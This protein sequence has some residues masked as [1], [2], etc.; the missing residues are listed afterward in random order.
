MSDQIFINQNSLQNTIAVNQKTYQNSVAVSQTSPVLSV[1]GMVGAVII[2]P[3][4]IGLG[5]VNNTSDLN[6]PISF[7]VASA[8][9][10]KTDLSAFN[11]LNNFVLN[12]YS[13]WNYAYNTI[14]SNQNNWNFAYNTVNAGY[15]NWNYAYNTVNNYSANWNTAYQSVSTTNALALSAGYWNS[16]YSYVQNNSGT[17]WNYQGTDLKALSANWQSTYVTVSTLSANWNTAYQSVS[18]TNFLNLSSS[19]WNSVYSLINTT[20]ATTFNVNNLNV[21]GTSYLNNINNSNTITFNAS[22]IG[23]PQGLGT[24]IIFNIGPYEGS[25]QY[26]ASFSSGG[27][28]VNNI[29]YSNEFILNGGDQVYWGWNYD[30][31]VSVFGGN[32]GDVFSIDTINTG[33]FGINTNRPN[34]RLTVSGNISS[35]STIY[36]GTGNSKNW[37]NVYSQVYNLSANWNLG[38]QSVSTTNALNLSSKYWNTAYSLVSG[39]IISTLSLPQSANWNSTYVTVSSLSAN[40]NL[41]YQAVS[42]V[43]LLSLSSTY[44]NNVYSQVYQLSGGW[45]SGSGGSAS[46]SSAVSGVWQS[47][48]VTVSTLS[49][50]WNFAY[51]ISN[52]YSKTSAL[53]LPLSGGQL[54][55]FVTSTSSLSAQGTITGYNISTNSQVQFLTGGNFVKVYQFY[56]SVTNSL[57]TVFN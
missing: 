49:A 30:D 25:N 16:A 23:D 53:Y 4:T 5:N 52:T 13:N 41:G 20:T 14:I 18:T 35:D 12:N 36:D 33:Y 47:T 46:I 31:G 42:T 34:E 11:I 32:V 38:Y 40:W 3:T 56:N 55:G 10:L 29:I 19:Y 24:A 2:T 26:Q 50:N 6:K 27:F 28:T 39:G 17:T 37:N 7:A 54:T 9:S 45:G 22:G 21:N 15:A 51:N 57:D 43:N 8:L 44:W 48:S 1:N